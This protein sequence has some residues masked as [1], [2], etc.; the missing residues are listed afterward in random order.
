MSRMERR[1]F[2]VAAMAAVAGCSD[3]HRPPSTRRTGGTAPAPPVPAATPTGPADWNALGRGLRGRLIRPDDAAYDL[4]RRLYVPRFDRI[5]PAGIAYC[6]NPEDVAECLAFGARARVPVAVRSGGHG[7]AGWSSGTGLVVDV[8]PMDAVRAEGGAGGGPWW[9][10]GPGS[11]T[12]TTGW[13]MSGSG[14]PPG[15]APP[16]A[17]PG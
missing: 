17:S 16:W 12:C 5:R 4:A 14:S 8:S 3:E 1:G 11:S 6:E 13:P 2:L 9:A 15:P 10:P 7:Y